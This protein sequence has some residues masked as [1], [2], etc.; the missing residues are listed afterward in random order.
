MTVLETK[1]LTSVLSS[2]IFSGLACD[3]SSHE[4]AELLQVR[5]PVPIAWSSCLR[6]QVSLGDVWKGLK[7]A[8]T[9]TGGWFREEG[10]H[11]QFTGDSNICE[12]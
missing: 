1:S 2:F 8:S 9:K 10:L 4:R 6:F 3:F 12:D 5:S 11:H 7:A